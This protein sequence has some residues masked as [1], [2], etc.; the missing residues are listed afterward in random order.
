LAGAVGAG[1]GSMVAAL[2]PAKKGFESTLELMDDKGKKLSAH[3]EFLKKA[4]DEDTDAFNDVMS[5]MRMPKKSDEDKKVRDE[6]IQAGY[7][8]ATLVPF[9][10]AENCVG[11]TK[12]LIEVAEKGN[13]ASASDVGVGA[14]M[15]YSGF[16]SAIL[17]VEINLPNITDD[18][19]KKELLGKIDGLREEIIQNR[20][21]VLEIVKSKI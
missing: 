21:K 19:F 14:L 15:A 9:A 11:L 2:T 16:E 13:P 20:D 18:K 1:L 10:T 7:K 17:N 4:I 8:T 5:A 6:A 3:L 12:E